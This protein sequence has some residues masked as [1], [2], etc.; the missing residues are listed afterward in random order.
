LD[1]GITT[2]SKIS[3]QSSI[4]PVIQCSSVFSFLDAGQGA[5]FKKK[6]NPRH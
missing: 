4:N 2:N 3:L 6:H 1:Y 5:V